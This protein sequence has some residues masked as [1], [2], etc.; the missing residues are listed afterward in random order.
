MKLS[1]LEQCYALALLYGL[2]LIDHKHKQRGDYHVRRD[3][4]TGELMVWPEIDEEALVRFVGEAG[5][6]LAE[7]WDVKID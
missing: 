2:S 1:D 7:G 5:D 6:K 4:H 3:P